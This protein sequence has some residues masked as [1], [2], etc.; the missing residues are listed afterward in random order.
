MVVQNNDKGIKD[1]PKFKDNR[2][3]T[4]AQGGGR[5]NNPN[6]QSMADLSGFKNKLAE[7]D[8]PDPADSIDPS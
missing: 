3:I 6:A 1:S 7:D 8:N 2:L 4:S 5:G